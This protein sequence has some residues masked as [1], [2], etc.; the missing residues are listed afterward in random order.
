MMKLYCF[1]NA[2]GMSTM[3]AQ[4]KRYV[5]AD[6]H[7]IPVELAGRGMRSSEPLYK[8]FEELLEDVMHH[9][10]KDW[11][12][13][14]YALF[15]HSMGSTIAFEVAHRMRE[16]GLQ[17]PDHL[18]L[19]ARRPPHS[20]REKVY[21]L[22]GEEEFNLEMMKLG[23]INEELFADESY[24]TFFMPI[25]KADIENLEKYKPPL[26]ECQQVASD[27]SVLYGTEDTPSREDLLEWKQ[28]TLGNFRMQAFSGG[29]FY[30]N[31][32]YIDV[33]SLINSTLEGRLQRLS[34]I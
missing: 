23:G 2:G 20:R 32:K 30:L 11:S 24:R 17:P 16:R 13:E 22:L 5:R 12:D 34:T 6:V 7:C 18:F 29:H 14:P 27:M 28:Y 10:L 15:G 1:P 9:V 19:S 21:H 25:L 8:S 4:W 31:Y 33:I 26:R 3:Y